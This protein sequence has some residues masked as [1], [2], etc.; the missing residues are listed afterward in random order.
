MLFVFCFKNIFDFFLYEYKRL[1][2]LSMCLIVF[3]TQF[4]KDFNL[5][6]SLGETCLWG[7]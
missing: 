7:F 4:Q 5:K 6:P 3:V 1:V 2:A